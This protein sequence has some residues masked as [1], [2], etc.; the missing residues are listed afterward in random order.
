MDAN[1]F[2]N[3]NQDVIDKSIFALGIAERYKFGENSE[4]DVVLTAFTGALTAALSMIE[5]I[6][7]DVLEKSVAS[8]KVTFEDL[9]KGIKFD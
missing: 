9:M 4:N 1:K 2:R 5:E 8:R 7:K 3:L 6:N